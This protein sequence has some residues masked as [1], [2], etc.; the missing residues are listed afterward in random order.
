MS[1]AKKIIEGLSKIKETYDNI[2]SATALNSKLT[3]E[4]KE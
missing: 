1:E 4:E 3:P 2:K